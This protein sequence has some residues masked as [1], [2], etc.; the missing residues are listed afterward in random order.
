MLDD[1]ATTWYESW[2]HQP[3][4]YGDTSACHA[5]SASPTY[6]LSEQ[7]GGIAPTSPGFQTVRIAPRMFDLDWARV[8]YPSPR[9]PIVVEWG[10]RGRDGM[11]MQIKLPRRVSGVLDIPGLP[12]KALTGGKHAFTA[13]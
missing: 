9:G 12:Q 1:G 11:N 3:K 13:E 10:R 4:S 2:N 7:I 6:H 8:R 5:W